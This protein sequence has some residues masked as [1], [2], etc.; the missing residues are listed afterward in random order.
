MRIIVFGDDIDLNEKIFDLL[1]KMIVFS[2]EELIRNMMGPE[3]RNQ[4]R[5]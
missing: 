5:A 2:R 1:D 4:W 3:D